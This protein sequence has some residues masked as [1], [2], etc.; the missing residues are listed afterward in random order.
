MDRRDYT[1]TLSLIRMSNLITKILNT[2]KVIYICFLLLKL[3]SILN[4]Y[5]A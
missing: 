5:L 4:K 3:V 2:E 1:F